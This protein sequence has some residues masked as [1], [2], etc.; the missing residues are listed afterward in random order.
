VQPGVPFGKEIKSDGLT[1]LVPH[2]FQGK[3]DISLV[4]YTKDLTIKGKVISS[5]RF[6]A[7]DLPINDNWYDTDSKYGLPVGE[8]K[9][10]SE[11]RRHLY[12]WQDRSWVGLVVRFY[13]VWGDY[14]WRDVYC[15][16][17]AS[18]R[19]GVLGK[20]RSKKNAGKT[21]DLKQLAREAE[22]S[23]KRMD[24]VVKKE[25]LT[26]IEMLVEAAKR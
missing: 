20:S 11:E 12:R 16:F 15:Y 9:E 24:G 10:Y 2:K 17:D 4:A 13:G 8:P 19:Y 5:A 25:L 3:K 22:K 7:F 1:V 26:P 6:E 23:V 14:D 18:S 21:P